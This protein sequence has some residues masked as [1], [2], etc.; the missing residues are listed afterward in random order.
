[1][2]SE[3]TRNE[4]ADDVTVI[5]IFSRGSLGPTHV[6]IGAGRGGIRKPSV[7]FCEEITTIERGFLARGPWGGRVDDD[8]L[9]A[10]VRAVRRAIGETVPEPK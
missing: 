6:P 2:I 9:G 1:V 8:L 5:P 3:D 10:V 4:V 7:L